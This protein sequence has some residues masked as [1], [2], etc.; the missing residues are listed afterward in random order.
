[1][2]LHSLCRQLYD[3]RSLR[4][5]LRSAQGAY[6]LPKLLFLSGTQHE[7]STLLGHP[8]VQAHSFQNVTIIYETLH[9]A[10]K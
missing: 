4:Q 9:W 8:N 2:R 10:I 7:L 5:P 1:M 6:R 3:S